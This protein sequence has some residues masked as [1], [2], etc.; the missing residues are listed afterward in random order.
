MMAAN[1]APPPHARDQTPR[2]R[3]PTEHR[4]ALPPTAGLCGDEPR[5]AVAALV[6]INAELATAASAAGSARARMMS[7]GPSQ[8]H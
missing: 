5:R 2:R 7:G 1:E 8:P 4:T 3:Q 6:A